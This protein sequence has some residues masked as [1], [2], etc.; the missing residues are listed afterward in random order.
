MQ[1]GHSES[2]SANRGVCPTTEQWQSALR[3]N[4]DNVA[5][6]DY[7]SHLQAC[8]ACELTVDALTEPSDTF[9]RELCSQPSTD[10]DEPAFRSL[11]ANL[12]RDSRLAF[13]SE[14]L[15][16]PF[17]LGNYQV[18]AALGRGASGSV[19]RATHVPLDRPVAI[20][21]LRPDHDFNPNQVERFLKEIRAVARL[22]H[23]NLIRA[24][25]A[26]E[27]DGRH[28]LAMEFVPGVDLSQVVATCAPLSIANACEA[29]RQTAIGLKHL[30]E[31]GFVHR[32]LK[33]SNLL[34]TSARQIKLLDLGLVQTIPG[35]GATDDSSE[36][37]PSKQPHWPDGT[38]DYMP[39]EQWNL[40]PVDLRSDLYSLGCTLFKLLTGTAPYRPL[41]DGF[42]DRC[43]AHCKAAI[44]SITALRPDVPIELNRI[45]S[46]LLS[47]SPEDR[48]GSVDA[49]LP[50]LAPWCRGADLDVLITEAGIEP[51]PQASTTGPKLTRRQAM[52]AGALGIAAVAFAAS[53][54]RHAPKTTIEF[55]WRPLLPAEPRV[56]AAH[57]NPPDSLW[58]SPSPDEFH[59]RSEQPLLLNFGQPSLIRGYR[60]HVEFAQNDWHGNAGIFFRFHQ[61]PG[62]SWKTDPDKPVHLYQTIRLVHDVQQQSHRLE[63][64]ACRT[65][66]IDG[67]WHTELEQ[68]F[69]SVPVN[70]PTDTKHVSLEIAMRETGFPIV[71]W[72]GDVLPTNQWTISPDGLDQA[73][74]EFEQPAARFAGRL[75]L[76]AGGGETTFRNPKLAYVE[77][78][79]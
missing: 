17:R 62:N 58:Q 8:E 61:P 59:V 37:P 64:N 21:L 10:D 65:Q 45:V 40:Q 50:A 13:E 5:W 41:P 18:H 69:A 46:K 29:I 60:M 39:P 9:V 74:S 15:K 23:P 1:T 63:W 51:A 42:A 57:A 2:Y 49:L 71:S 52:L 19:F 25:D 11:Y 16:V 27:A 73:S 72:C 20:K 68:S 26:G 35:H 31:N 12:V 24:T 76:I 7:E 66:K 77:T 3:G 53:R 67:I 48:F 56:L 79:T 34:L 55:G 44:P 32:D 36:D 6:N 22:D 78:A 43:A 47:K 14:P 54:W 38:P 30:H 70:V 33:P 28:F 4:V 75:G